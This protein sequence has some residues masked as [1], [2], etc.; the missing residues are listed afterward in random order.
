[1]PSKIE[2]T[3]ETWNPI[4][5][6][7]KISPGCQN[8]YAERMSKRLA[9]RHGYPADEPFRVTFHWDRLSHPMKW[10]KPRQIFVCSMGDLF[11]ESVNGRFI[12]QVWMT[13]RNASKQHT[14][15]ILTKRPQRLKWW[16]ETAA[17]YK[18]W[19]AEDIWPPNAWLGVTA[20]NQEQADKRIPILLQIPAAVRFVSVEPMLEPVSLR[21]ASWEPIKRDRTTHHLDGLRRLDWVIIGAESGP[22]ARKV[23]N[24]HI[25]NLLLQCSDAHVPVFLKQAWINGKLVKMPHFGG[26]VWDQFPAPAA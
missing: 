4:T 22:K 18:H 25:L 1:M 9:G 3:E 13:I 16:T 20:E 8:C 19:P 24:T 6:C 26:Q 5:G 12:N 14:F 10:K 23:D 15:I 21:W 7:T 11:H 2:W 17:K